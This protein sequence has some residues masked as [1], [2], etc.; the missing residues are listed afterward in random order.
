MAL[1]FVISTAKSELAPPAPETPTKS[2][3]TPRATLHRRRKS[4]V[5]TPSLRVRNTRRS[6]GHL[7]D[8]VDP[9]QQLARTLGITL[10]E[11][12]ATDH[13][14]VDFF[15]K[16]LAERVMRLE[17]HVMSLQGTT[18]TSISIH[19]ADAHVTLGV[20]RDCL[21]KESEFGFIRLVDREVEEGVEDFE[22]D[23]MELKEKLDEVDLRTLNG[24]SIAR[25]HLVERW[26]R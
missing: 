4:S 2:P 10:P 13:A 9:E 6:S 21:L 24:R 5:T 17:S 12:T 26:K 20:L 23:V 1:K 22:R 14:R 25:D 15:D 19:L 3:G 7:D 8:D 16:A 11:S 18:E